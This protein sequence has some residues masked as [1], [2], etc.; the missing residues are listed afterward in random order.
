MSDQVRDWYCRECLKTRQSF[1]SSMTENRLTLVGVPAFE[2]HTGLGR[3]LFKL[4]PVP[5]T[6]HF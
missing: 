4:S 3:P 1:A 2:R 5:E 6:G